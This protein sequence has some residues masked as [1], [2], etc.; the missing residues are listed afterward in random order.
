MSQPQ[1][2]AVDLMTLLRNASLGHYPENALQAAAVITAV[3]PTPTHP[4]STNQTLVRF[5]LFLHRLCVINPFA[6]PT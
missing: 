2:K 5:G 4:Y 3:H 6:R 1:L